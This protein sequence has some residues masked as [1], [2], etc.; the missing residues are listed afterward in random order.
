MQ[1]I[2]GDGGR[3][4]EHALARDVVGLDALPMG[5]RKKAAGGRKEG[6]NSRQDRT[7]RSDTLPPLQVGSSFLSSPSLFFF[8]L[9][10][11]VP[12]LYPNSSPALG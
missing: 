6:A 1:H 12:V 8:S 3:T 11:A 7:N 10:E 2:L 4:G 9:R 5:W